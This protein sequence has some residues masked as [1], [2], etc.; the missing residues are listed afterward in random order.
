MAAPERQTGGA[1]SPTLHSAKP[2]IPAHRAHHRNISP[3]GASCQ[4]PKLEL[5]REAFL[6]RTSTPL[7]I[8]RNACPP[9]SPTTV[10]V[11]ECVLHIR[12]PVTLPPRHAKKRNNTIYIAEAY[13]IMAR[14]LDSWSMTV[15]ARF[16]RSRQILLQSHL[17]VHAAKS[18]TVSGKGDPSRWHSPDFRS[19][20][21]LRWKGSEPLDTS[22]SPAFKER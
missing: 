1:S 22:R 4:L 17:K 16:A 2:T 12:V 9:C 15:V 5:L 20:C 11:A 10:R 14:M 19:I 21:S 18:T 7:P 3:T 8:S 13:S 6:L